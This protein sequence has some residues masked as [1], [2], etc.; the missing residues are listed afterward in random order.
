MAFLETECSERAEKQWCDEE[1][2]THHPKRP[3]LVPDL[4]VDLVAKINLLVSTLT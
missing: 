1:S 2:D 4:M 3:Q